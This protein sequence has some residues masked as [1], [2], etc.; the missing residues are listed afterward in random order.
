[1]PVGPADNIRVITR[2]V[3]TGETLYANTYYCKRTGGAS[4]PDSEVLQDM[5]DWMTNLFLALNPSLDAELDLGDCQVDLVEVDG[6]YNPDPELNTAK[7]KVVRSLGYIS[8]GFAPAASGEEYDGI[9]TGVVT[10]KC[11]T[12]GPRPRK[13]ISGFVENGILQ[14]LFTNGPLGALTTFAIRWLAGPSFS[15][16]VGTMSLVSAIFEAFDGTFTID[17]TG[18]TQVTRKIGRGS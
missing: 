1:M 13:S 3:G 6:V 4:V 12:I 17:N 11:F 9:C 5:E 10:P 15:Y 7:V 2:V 14:K 8:P 18:G 16:F